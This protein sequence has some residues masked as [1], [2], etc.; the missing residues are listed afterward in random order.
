MSRTS[1]VAIFILTT[2]IITTVNSQGPPGQGQGQVQGQGPPGQGQNPPGQGQGPPGQGQGPP[3]QG[4]P[5]QGQGTPGQGQG[6]PGQGQGQGPPGQGQPPNQQGQNPYPPGGPPSQ[7]GMPPQGQ[8][9]GQQPGM[10]QQ[11]Q[12]QMG[13]Q[14]GNQQGMDHPGQLPGPGGQQP[15]LAYTQLTTI[16]A[17]PMDPGGVPVTTT[18]QQEESTTTTYFSDDRPALSASSDINGDKDDCK[19]FKV[20]SMPTD[21]CDL[22]KLNIHENITKNCHKECKEATNGSHC[23]FIQCKYRDLS[24]YKGTTFNATSIELLLLK[25]IKNQ[26]EMYLG[27]WRKAIKASMSYC[28]WDQMSKETT[29]PP[30]PSTTDRM[31]YLMNNAIQNGQGHYVNPEYQQ[32]TQPPPFTTPTA[33]TEPL[34]VRQNNNRYCDIPVFVFRVVACMRVVNFVNCPYFNINNTACMGKRNEIISC[35]RDLNYT[36]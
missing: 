23:C 13:G 18:R 2:S 20:S 28:L 31:K 32:H 10:D 8:M 14:Q 22:P 11:G 26:S 21:C 17:T 3:G 16:R 30:V 19:H 12:G 27:P 35:G 4:Q 25:S 5:G 24:I 33:S 36:V 15:P 9:G 7:G 1:I 29:R 6:P 34:Y